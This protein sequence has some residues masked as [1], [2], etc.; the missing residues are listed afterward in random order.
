MFRGGLSLKIIYFEQF[1]RVY[2][3]VKSQLMCTKTKSDAKEKNSYLIRND[4][5][6]KI[7]ITYFYYFFLPSQIGITA[8]TKAVLGQDTSLYIG[9]ND[10]ASDVKVYPDEFTLWERWE[11]MM[12]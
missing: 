7:T 10:V 9:S 1:I 8:L 11:R 12:S 2:C 5:E 6:W 3:Q 4:T